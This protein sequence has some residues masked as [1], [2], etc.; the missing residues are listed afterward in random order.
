[1]KIA[2]LKELAALV[3]SITVEEVPLVPYAYL[4][5]LDVEILDFLD[6]YLPI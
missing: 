6:Y 1:M 4:Y 5:L 3:I 2:D